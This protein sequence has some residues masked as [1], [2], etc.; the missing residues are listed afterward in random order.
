MKKFILLILSA[1]LILTACSSNTQTTSKE[2]LNYRKI[3]NGVYTKYDPHKFDGISVPKIYAGEYTFI[4]ADDWSEMFFS[5]PEIKENYPHPNEINFDNETEYGSSNISAQGSYPSAIYGQKN[6][7]L[8]LVAQ[9]Y[10]NDPSPVQ[11]DL[12]FMTLSE[13]SDRFENDVKKYISTDINYV[14]YPIT[15]DDFNAVSSNNNF[16]NPTMNWT[17]PEDFYYIKAR[18]AV[19]GIE[20]FTGALNYSGEYRCG[21]RIEAIYSKRGIEFFCIDFPY[22][23]NEEIA[24]DREFIEFAEAE[25]MVADKIDEQLGH[26]N[27]VIEDA[28]LRYVSIWNNDKFIMYPTWEFYYE[29]MDGVTADAM[30]SH[31]LYRINAFT[32][33][34]ITW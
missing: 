15:K 26:E 32:G 30:F 13:V 7:S 23:F 20:V 8:Y 16:P 29:F 31:P 21:C 3:T 22:N 24:P 5:K 27:I 6:N 4:N 1:I 18:Q 28:A 11:K 14:V 25:K 17:E 10:F 2:K 19:D 34:D 12:D 9:H 33:E